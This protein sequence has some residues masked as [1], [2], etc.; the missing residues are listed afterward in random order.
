MHRAAEPGNHGTVELLNQAEAQAQVFPTQVRLPSHHS[1]CI[2][3]RL[4]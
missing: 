4:P 2:K 3:P 1:E